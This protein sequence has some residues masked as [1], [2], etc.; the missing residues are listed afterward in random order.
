MDFKAIAIAVGKVILAQTGVAP[1]ITTVGEMRGALGTLQ[2]DILAPV[3]ADLTLEQAQ[4][5]LAASIA[6][7]QQQDNTI[8]DNANAALAEN[9]AEDQKPPTK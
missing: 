7:S 5:H 2:H 8:R 9:A 3:P 1:I 4:T 6:T